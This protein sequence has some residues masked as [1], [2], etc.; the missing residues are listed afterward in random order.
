LIG[1]HCPLAT[2]EERE[3]ARKDRTLGQARL[4]F[5]RVHQYTLYD[6]AVDSSLAGAETCAA[7]IADFLASGAPPGAFRQLRQRSGQA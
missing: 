1:V 3:R 5:E 7:Q 2:L 6:F 4:Q